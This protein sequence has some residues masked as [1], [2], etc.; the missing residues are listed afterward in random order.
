MLSRGSWASQECRAETYDSKSVYVVA[1]PLPNERGRQLA[2]VPVGLRNSERQRREN[3]HI[4]QTRTSGG[5]TLGRQGGAWLVH[6]DMWERETT[7]GTT[8]WGT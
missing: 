4:I 7:A 3:A 1:D 6:G 2:H 5:N 8:H